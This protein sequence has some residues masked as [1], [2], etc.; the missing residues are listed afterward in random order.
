MKKA[1]SETPVKQQKYRAHYKLASAHFTGLL[2]CL[3][4][5]FSPASAQHTQGSIKPGPTS[6]QLDLFIKPHFTATTY[7]ENINFV[8]AIPSTVSPSLNVSVQTGDG[9]SNSMTWDLATI[10][11]YELSVPGYTGYRFYTIIGTDATQT[12]MNYV[13]GT[14]IR[15]ARLTFTGAPGATPM[16]L[17]DLTGVGWG[18]ANPPAGCFPATSTCSN[19]QSVFYVQVNTLG[20]VSGDPLS[21]NPFYSISGVSTGGNLGGNALVGTI[22]SITLPLQLLSFTGQAMECETKLAWQT[23]NEENTSHF[24]IEQ[25]FNGQ[26]YTKIGTVPAQGNGPGRSY[27]FTSS[28]PAGQAY[29]RLKMVDLDAS[30]TYSP[31]RHVNIRCGMENMLR[32][33]PNPAALSTPV[34]A[35]INVAQAQLNAQ[36]QLLQADGRTL[37]V[38]TVALKPGSNQVTVPVAGLNPGTYF[39]KVN[40]ASGEVLGNV[41]Q[42]VLY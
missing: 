30:F 19:G 21:V 25:S 40:N 32:V 41:R 26:S 31:I 16:Y 14:E 2:F 13:S 38:V 12:S 36:L 18:G 42:V 28:Q 15:V 17:V 1:L 3:L 9:L 35:E 37:R 11:P 33:Y 4:S 22:G 6:N 5:V 8:V 29:Y 23:A 10:P 39:I 24:E 20:E 34:M 27:R 7:L